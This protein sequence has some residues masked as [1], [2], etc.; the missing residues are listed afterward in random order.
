LEIF[1]FGPEVTRLFGVWY[2][3]PR[4]EQRSTGVVVCPPMG[5]EL[6]RATVLCRRL[7]EVFS[8]RRYPTLRF[9][10]FGTGDSAGETRE[11]TIAQWLDDIGTAT[12]ELRSRSSCSQVCL[13]GL[14]LGA[15]LAMLYGSRHGVITAIALLD[16]ICSGKEYI[17]HLRRLES[18][19][20]SELGDPPVDQLLAEQDRALMGM[21]H[22]AAF[23]AELEALDLT[24]LDERPAHEIALFEN[25]VGDPESDGL[26]EAAGLS[27]GFERR[28]LGTRTDTRLGGGMWAPGRAPQQVAGW[29]VA[30]CP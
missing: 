28:E 11:A 6:L 14:R 9:D 25:D 27:Q 3:P 12:E 8:E 18:T 24:A 10:Y 20:W 4:A 26:S 16:P 1:Y 21:S 2:D 7:A 22:S 23:L 29:L 15:T 30:K 5:H 19:A 13:V 17:R